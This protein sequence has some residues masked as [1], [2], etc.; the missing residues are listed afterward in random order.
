MLAHIPGTEHLPDN[1]PKMLGGVQEFGY[2]PKRHPRFGLPPLGVAPQQP[3]AWMQ[4]LQ[5]KNANK[6]PDQEARSQPPSPRPPPPPEAT[7]LL[8]ALPGEAAEL[9]PQSSLGKGKG[10]AKGVTV[11]EEVLATLKDQMARYTGAVKRQ[12]REMVSRARVDELEARLVA[13]ARLEGDSPLV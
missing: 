3:P 5:P 7:T 10:R 6:A 11:S 2:A 1:Y 12:S 9:P 13:L 8:G 4:A